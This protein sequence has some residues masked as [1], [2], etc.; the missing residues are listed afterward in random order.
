LAKLRGTLFLINN[1]SVNER[2]L[3]LNFFVDILKK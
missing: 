3:S 1:K 2:N